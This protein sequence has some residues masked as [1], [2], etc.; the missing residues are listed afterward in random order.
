MS[1]RI[2]VFAQGLVV[3]EIRGSEATEALVLRHATRERGA[4][5]A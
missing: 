5:A 2:L 3:A 1:D 4:Q